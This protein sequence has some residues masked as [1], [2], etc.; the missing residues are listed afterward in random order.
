MGDQHCTVLPWG[1]DERAE[2]YYNDIGYAGAGY[3]ADAHAAHLLGMVHHRDSGTAGVRSAFVGGNSVAARP[4]CGNEFLRTAGCREW[5]SCSAQRRLTTPV[6]A[7]VLV[8]WPSG[9]VH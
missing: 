5:T 8:F 4:K 7:P 9:S 6:A 2:F 3:V 1:T